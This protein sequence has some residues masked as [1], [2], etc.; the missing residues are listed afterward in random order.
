MRAFVRNYIQAEKTRREE[1]GEKGFSL[2]ELIV[3]V[4]ILG[5]LAAVAIPI[6][7]GIQQNA[8]QSSL[9]AI[10][11]NA[12]SQAAAAYASETP[13]TAGEGYAPNLTADS[14]LAVTLTLAGTS[15]EDFCV[16]GVAEGLDNATAGPGCD[17]AAGTGD[18][19]GGL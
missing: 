4:V 12:A 1:S 9:D 8:E 15:L 6:F 16:T 17:A 19:T 2:I 18:D 5:V 13:P 11:A 7:L 10:T 14:D 3:V